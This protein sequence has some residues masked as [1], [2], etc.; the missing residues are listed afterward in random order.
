VTAKV[1]MH[2]REHPH[3]RVIVTPVD[4]PGLTVDADHADAAMRAALGRVTRR[5]RE[6]SGSVRA[7]LA[8]PVEAEL[9]EVK[10]NIGRRK[11]AKPLHI[12]VGLVVAARETRNGSIYVVSAPE[13]PHFRIAV[14]DRSEIRERAKDELR[15][16]IDHWELDAVLSCDEVGEVRLVQVELPFPSPSE[17]DARDDAF[18]LEEA[19]D[20]LT[21]QAA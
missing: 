3:G 17:T 1:L 20:E 4:F 6:M 11:G 18:A 14:G 16:A 15:R 10:L 12:T 2:V 21:L 13:I 7:M 9:D 19:G 8:A 5:L